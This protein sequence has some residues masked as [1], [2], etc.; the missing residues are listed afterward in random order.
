MAEPLSAESGSDKP[1]DG[2]GKKEGEKV[3]QV[4]QRL[5]AGSEWHYF[6]KKQFLS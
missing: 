2:S 3:K 1:E 4:V 6:L 5:M